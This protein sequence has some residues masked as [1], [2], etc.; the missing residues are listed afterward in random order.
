MQQIHSLKNIFFDAVMNII[1]QN[2]AQG[3][4]LFASILRLKKI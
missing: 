3:Q 4:Q 1:H 2:F